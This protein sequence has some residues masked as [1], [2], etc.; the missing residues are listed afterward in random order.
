MT[1]VLVTG[2]SGGLG[3][4]LVPRL[5][6]AG[7]TTRIM[8]RC[9]SKL[10]AQSSPLLEWVQAD[11][12][13]GAGLDNAV[14]DVDVIVNAA[15]SSVKNERAVDVDGTRRLLELSSRANVSHFLHVSITGIDQIPTFPYYK[16]KLEA[17]EVLKQGNMPYSIL[18]ASM[19]HS[20]IDLFLQM[21]ARVPLVLLMPSDFQVQPMDTGEAAD[22]IVRQIA[23]A[24]AGMLPDITGPQVLNAGEAAK[25]WQQARRMRRP[26]IR[27]P[28]PFDWAKGFR[29]GR[30]VSQNKVGKITWADWLQR[31]Y[32]APN[33]AQ[34]TQKVTP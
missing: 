5:V 7:Y 19:F 6:A 18:R 22:A 16:L 26:I 1:R 10:D 4:E 3:Y 31:T 9:A 14:H 13:A 29:Q 33:H 20:L 12:A 15:T 21:F 27:L 28:L 11:M 8:S 34:L 2:G 24:P 25:L 23:A 32:G 17:E 30:Q